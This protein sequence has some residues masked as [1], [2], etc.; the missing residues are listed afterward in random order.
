MDLIVRHVQLIE[1]TS[2]GKSMMNLSKRDWIITGIGCASAYFLFKKFDKWLSYQV[3]LWFNDEGKKMRLTMN[4]PREELFAKLQEVI[5]SDKPRIVEIGIG[6]GTN[7]S[8]YPKNSQI[9]GVEPLAEQK[10]LIKEYFNEMKKN[11]ECDD[12]LQIE[13][14]ITAGA[15]D[16]GIIKANSVDAVVSTAVLCSVCNVT[17]VLNEVDRILK[18]GGIFIFFEHI[19]AK[20]R[21]SN[22]LQTILRPIWYRMF[23]KC[24]L[25]GQ[26]DQTLTRRFSSNV[27]LKYYKY[28]NPAEKLIAAFVPDW[29]YG[30]MIKDEI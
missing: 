4:G 29:C 19:E 20:N 18:P 8:F 24:E 15:E 12:T 2:I 17:N 28:T 11:K 27:T 23:R 10:E 16:M 3:T 5:N 7:F 30:W 6:G 25:M 26:Y 13:Q 22:I 1:R 9:I 14:I 21:T